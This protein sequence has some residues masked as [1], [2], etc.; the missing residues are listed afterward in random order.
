MYQHGHYKQYSNLKF[1]TIFSI[2]AH[3]GVVLTNAPMF[4]QKVD[5]LQPLQ[6]TRSFPGG[7]QHQAALNFVIGT[8]TLGPLL[9][10]KYYGDNEFEMLRILQEMPCHFVVGGRLAQKTDKTPEF[11]TGQSEVDELPAALQSK[12]TLM[13]DFRVDMSSTE[14]RQQ[15]TQTSTQTTTTTTTTDE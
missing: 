1:Y 4:K 15:Q 2:S 11:I 10:P 14:L 3:W 7:K 6:V 8:D 13:P 9:N 12:F 5:L